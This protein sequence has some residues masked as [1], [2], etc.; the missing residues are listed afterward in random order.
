MTNTILWNKGLAKWACRWSASPQVYSTCEFVLNPVLDPYIHSK[1][2]TV[3]FLHLLDKDNLAQSQA[4]HTLA[5][6]YTVCIYVEFHYHD[7]YVDKLVYYTLMYVYYSFKESG[8]LSRKNHQGSGTL[9]LSRNL[10]SWWSYMHPSKLMW[11]ELLPHIDK[12][13]ATVNITYFSFTAFLGNW[14]WDLKWLLN[15]RELIL[16]GLILD[17]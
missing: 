8:I 13:S 10:K 14:K 1:P 17:R 3:Y 16:K 9:T 7:Y 6:E 12:L 15:P 2:V 11:T 5:V 4:F